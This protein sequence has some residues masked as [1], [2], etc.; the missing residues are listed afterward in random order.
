MTVTIQESGVVFGEFEAADLFAIERALCHQ[1]LAEK[2]VKTVEFI[3]RQQQP[4]KSGKPLVSLIEARSSVPRQSGDL[5]EEIR[6]KMQHSLIVW[7]CTVSG[8]HPALSGD[9]P[10]NLSH[11]RHLRYTLR[12]ILVVPTLPDAYLA[13]MTD[14][15]RSA[16]KLDCRLWGIDHSAVMVL[17]ESRAAKLGLIKAH[18]PSP[19]IDCRSY[20]KP[21]IHSTKPLTT[22]ENE[23]YGN[24][25]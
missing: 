1:R 3:V 6:L 8:R 25:E 24:G 19:E 14:T 22:S 15:F 17:N 9:L 2:G 12:L 16:I 13:Q 20:M 23:T 11:S 5:F 18:G 21:R 10:T 7:F 4:G